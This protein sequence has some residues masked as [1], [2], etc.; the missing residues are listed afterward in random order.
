MSF[1]FHIGNE[2]FVPHMRIC[3]RVSI[4][5]L[6]TCEINYMKMIHNEPMST[7]KPETVS[8]DFK[9]FWNSSPSDF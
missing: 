2:N 8:V 1:F 6:D 4:P 9:K 5:P 3:P 7:V